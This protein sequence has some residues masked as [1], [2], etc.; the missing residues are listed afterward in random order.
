ML[1]RKTLLPLISVAALAVP[2]A[3]AAA[4]PTATAAKDCGYS[5]DLGFTYVNK[6]KARKLSCSKAKGV[7]KSY[8]NAG[9]GDRSVNGYSCK[10][11]KVAESPVQFD[12]T[13]SCKKGKKKVSFIYTQNT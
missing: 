12:A 2:V 7:I 11:T 13:A 4:A 5:D 3:S 10:D 1:L 6:I 9:G 8:A